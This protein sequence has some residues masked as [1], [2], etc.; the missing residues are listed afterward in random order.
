M[1]RQRKNER[2]RKTICLKKVGTKE[3]RTT[4]QYDNLSPNE[5][6]DR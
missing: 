1:K 5:I 6:I 2:K 4:E 3:K